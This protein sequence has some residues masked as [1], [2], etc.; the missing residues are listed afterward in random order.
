MDRSA[1]SRFECPTSMRTVGL[2]ALDLLLPASS[3]ERGELASAA[4]TRRVVHGVSVLWQPSH[5]GHAG[6]QS[7]ADPA[8]HAASGNRS[9]L[10]ETQPEPSSARPR[11]LSVL[12]AGRLD[13]TAQPGLEHRYYV[14]SDAGWLP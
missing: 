12:A 10:S 1:T 9:S 13:R 3:G 6:G 14:Y 7:Q 11:D 2:A 5:G 8:P 4:A